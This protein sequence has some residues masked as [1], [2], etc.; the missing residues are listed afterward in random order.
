MESHIDDFD[1]LE[2]APYHELISKKNELIDN[3]EFDKAEAISTILKQRKVE[4]F[5][6]AL[7]ETENYVKQKIEELYESYRACCEESKSKAKQ[8]EMKFREDIDISYQDIQIRH[9]DEL[10]KLEKA[11]SLTI[12][13]EKSRPVAKQ[14]SLVTLAKKNA[15]QDRFQEAR[16]LT[17]DSEKA[18]S[19]EHKIRKQKID[20]KFNVI[21]SQY[22][23]KQRNE[24]YILRD[25]LRSSLEKNNQALSYQLENHL[26]QFKLSCLFLHRRSVEQL[27]SQFHKIEIKNFLKKTIDQTF[28]KKMKSVSGLDFNPLS[29]SPK[30]SKN[31]PQKTATNTKIYSTEIL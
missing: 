22:F 13:K 11:Y 26:K 7:E 2:N 9:I 28:Y 25:K 20:A 8:N 14:M 17:A 12:L 19:E 10:V 21:R 5:S 27:V 4:D 31:T 16:Q 3:L 29:A 30:I 15:K 1:D 24:I 6:Q 18:F 23:E